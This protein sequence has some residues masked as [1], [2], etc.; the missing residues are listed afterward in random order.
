MSICVKGSSLNEQIVRVCQNFVTNF[1]VAAHMQPDSEQTDIV[2]TGKLVVQTNDWKEYPNKL[3]DDLRQALEELLTK[4][5]LVR[6]CLASREAQIQTLQ[7]ENEALRT[8]NARLQKYQHY[9]DVAKE[10]GR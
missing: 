10:I 8:E 6:N 4:N 5:V 7:Q 9:V 3:M 2:L 1:V